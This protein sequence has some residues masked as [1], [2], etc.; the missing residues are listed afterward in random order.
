MSEKITTH[1]LNLELGQPAASVTVS[2]FKQAEQG[3]LPVTDAVTDEDGRAALAVNT[4]AEGVYR[5]VFATGDYFALLEKEIFYPSVTI[6]FN[7]SDPE[8]HYHVPLLLNRFG[9]STYRG[10]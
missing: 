6:D 1:I 7:L 9:Y 10:S 5:L 3:W 8:A 2:L 4:S